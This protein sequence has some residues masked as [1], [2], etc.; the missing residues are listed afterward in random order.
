[1]DE[2]IW[3]RTSASLAALKS[4]WRRRSI[5][6]AK[7][8][9]ES[10]LRE[11]H[12]S[13][14]VAVPADV[15]M[16][17]AL[18]ARMSSRASP[19]VVGVPEVRQT[20]AYMEVRPTLSAGSSREPPRI[21]MF[22]W[23]NGSSWS[24]SSKRIAPFG[25]VMR[26]GWTGLKVWRGGTGILAHGS[27]SGWWTLAAGDWPQQSGATE[28]ARVSAAARRVRQ[29]IVGLRRARGWFR[30][31]RRCDWTLETGCWRHGGCRLWLR[32]RPF[33]AG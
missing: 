27:A 25:S 22:P 28:R 31:G 2:A 26:V 15:S 16:L 10:C 12:E 32:R 20:R 14:V 8:E 24:S 19:E 23:T 29:V 4:G 17:A 30:C 6:C 1:M 5:A 13:D 11:D 18:A 21:M 33:E 3:R 9:S 7:T